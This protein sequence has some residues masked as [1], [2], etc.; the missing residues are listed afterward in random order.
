LLLLSESSRH[1]DALGNSSGYVGRNL[2]MNA[3]ANVQAVFEHQ[4]NDYKGVQ[5]TQIVHDLYESYPARGYY[6]H[7]EQQRYLTFTCGPI[8]L[9]ARGSVF[10]QPSDGA[11]RF[12]CCLKRHRLSSNSLRSTTGLTLLTDYVTRERR[13]WNGK[14]TIVR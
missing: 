2:M 8:A 11:A 1:A 4:L 14:I 6:G 10:K 13:C 7:G 3:H 12:P 9:L 5:A